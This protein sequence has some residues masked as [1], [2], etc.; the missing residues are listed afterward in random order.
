MKVSPPL[1]MSR[2][3]DP[4]HLVDALAAGRS[5]AGEDELADELRLVLRDH[6][7]DEAAQREAEQI[8]LIE[9]ERPDEGDGVAR[10]RGDRVGVLPFEAPTPRLSKAIT[11]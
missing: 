8:D 5:G 4:C 9:P 7:R 10:H 11:R 2:I 6:L 3:G 1:S